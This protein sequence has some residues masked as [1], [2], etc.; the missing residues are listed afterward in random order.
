VTCALAEGS[1]V[2][3]DAIVEEGGKRVSILASAVG[4][5]VE[6]EEEEEIEG[7][8]EVP[9]EVEVQGEAL[10]VVQ[11][12]GGVPVVDVPGIQLSVLCR[13]HNPVRLSYPC[14]VRDTDVVEQEYQK[15]ELAR[16]MAELRLRVDSLAPESTLRVKTA[17][18]VFDV[19]F[20][21]SVPAKESVTV[22]FSDG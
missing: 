2:S 9:M 18:G 8:I 17:G 3:L 15:L 4:A 22:L 7:V 20:L 10:A 21:F 12:E 6:M 1:G 5:D 19:T 11:E 16:K 13:T 14:S